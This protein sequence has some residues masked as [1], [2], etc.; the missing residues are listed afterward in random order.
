MYI[1]VGDYHLILHCS[2]NHF[3]VKKHTS[4]SVGVIDRRPFSS[5]YKYEIQKSLPLVQWTFDGRGALSLIP[6]TTATTNIIVS[7]RMGKMLVGLQALVLA[8]ASSTDNFMV[9]ISVGLDLMKNDNKD[10]Q[11]DGDENYV[12]NGNDAAVD[13][14]DNDQI[15]VQ[16]RSST[17]RRRGRHP[18]ERQEQQQQSQPKSQARS[19]QEKIHLQ[20]TPTTKK[21]RTN[22]VSLPTSG[23]LVVANCIISTSN[24]F[25]AYLAAL[26]GSH[27][28]TSMMNMRVQL[29]MPTSQKGDEDEGNDNGQGYDSNIV[30]KQVAS[31]LS[32]IAFGFLAFQEVNSARNK[33]KR[34]NVED[35]QQKQRH[36][37]KD[38]ERNSSSRCHIVARAFQLAVPMTLNNF[39]GGV[40]GGAV[41][42]TPS[43]SFVYGWIVSFVTMAGGYWIGSRYC[44][45]Q[46][47]AT[48][49][50]QISALL[51]GILSILSF[52]DTIS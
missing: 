13:D 36:E 45:Q 18:Q 42:I 26:G 48:D 34:D 25:G 3:T 50:S 15:E 30:E 1:R 41:G 32:S 52:V 9:G 2:T 17:T 16:S 31:L 19:N 5:T 23:M 8:L 47:L 46:Q 6:I 40:T 49:P 14:T 39:A 43:Q 44:Q 11:N 38:K 24:A 29:L 7:Y 35:D 27:M 4:T 28:I 37:N 51:F 22:P 12:G 20:K 21:F 10:L 33:Q